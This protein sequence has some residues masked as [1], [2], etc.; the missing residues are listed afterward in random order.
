MRKIPHAKSVDSDLRP[1]SL[2]PVLSK[3]L[4]GFVF[5]WLAPIVLPKIDSYQFGGV[6]N[7]SATTALIHLIHQWLAATEIP[8][9]LVRSCLIDFSQ[10]F[11]RINHN[12]L[13][14]KLQTLGVPPILLNWCASVLRNRQQR[15]KLGTFKSSWKPINAGVPQGTKLGPLF[16]LVMVNDFPAAFSLYKLIDDMTMVE[17]VSVP[18]IQTTAP[19]QEVDSFCQWATT[20]NMKLNV[21]KTKEFMVSFLKHTSQKD[22][23]TVNNEPLQTVRT[24][25][26]LG[27]HLTSDLKWSAHIDYI[28]A[29]ASKRLYAL[30]TLRRSGVPSRDLCS[31]FCYFIRPILEYACPVWHSS[32]TLKL[33]DEIEAIQRHAVKIIL[34]H[35]TYDEGLSALNLTTLF[36]RREHLC[37]SFYHKIITNPANKL[38]DLIPNSVTPAYNSRKPRTIPL[39]K[40]RTKRFKMSFLPNCVR[41]WDAFHKQIFKS[42]LAFQ[43]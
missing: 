31:V 33:S 10:A 43:L 28:C 13:L 1:I 34:P 5:N 22:P 4:V 23:L 16:F 35:L 8:Q 20:N 42:V 17:V 32:L 19:Q 12:I 36:D 29:K 18:V 9:T 25:K 2:T 40:C 3:V 39:F 21:K 11:D 27:V 37:R 30:R 24:T 26:L 6:K 15:V 41:K 14:C 38:N 7:S